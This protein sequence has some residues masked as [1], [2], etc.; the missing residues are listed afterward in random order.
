MRNQA[1]EDGVVRRGHGPA[2]AHLTRLV[3]IHECEF[4]SLYEKFVVQRHRQSNRIAGA[5]P[6]ASR[7]AAR[8]IPVLVASL[9]L[10]LGPLRICEE[11]DV[12]DPIGITKLMLADELV[13]NGLQLGPGIGQRPV[14]QSDGVS[15]CGATGPIAV[16]TRRNACDSIG[17]PAAHPSTNIVRRVFQYHGAN[18]AQGARA[19]PRTAEGGEP[20]RLRGGAE[21]AS[22]YNLHGCNCGAR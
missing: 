9:F 12:S 22:S 14:Q 4:V 20:R 10:Q 11:T 21:R 8:F 6:A 2:E 16:R 5:L 18:I 19:V 7:V 17:E 13:L 3:G 1:V 15:D